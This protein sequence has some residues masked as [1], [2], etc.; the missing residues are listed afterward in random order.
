LSVRSFK[1]L[2]MVQTRS[3]T[4]AG[5]PPPPN[6]W[7]EAVEAADVAEGAEGA[8]E[9]EELPPLNLANILTTARGGQPFLPILI[10]LLR[11]LNAV[12][13]D[14]LL[15]AF[16]FLRI[17]LQH[18]AVPQPSFRCQDN[19]PL[20]GIKVRDQA[21]PFHLLVD[22]RIG[23][24]QPCDIPGHHMVVHRRCEGPRL[25]Y[26]NHGDNFWVCVHCVRRA[27]ERYSLAFKVICYDLC[28][29][30]SNNY[31]SHHP[32]SALH[33]CVCQW[34]QSDA[35]LH[36]CTDCRIDESRDDH[37]A[38]FDLLTGYNINISPIHLPLLQLFVAMIPLVPTRISDFIDEHA[39]LGESTCTCGRSVT[40]KIQTYRMPGMP[41][42]AY[43]F[44]SLVRICSH[45]RMEKFVTLDF[46][47]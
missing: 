11:F 20:P 35:R 31:R 19:P 12:D 3:Q 9:A 18:P 24:R 27:W 2:Q 44:S 37:A 23:P 14:R 29:H 10:P 30:C 17:A 7:P 46:P 36:L 34:E 32:I 47:F 38:D 28:L 22:P 21:S 6:L 5:A 1:T 41:Q 43:D 40:D 39:A 15:K 25:G 13:L 42:P 33:Q 4:R 26:H 16:P 8:E 45:C